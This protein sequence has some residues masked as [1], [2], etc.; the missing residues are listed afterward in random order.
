MTSKISNPVL[1]SVRRALGRTAPLT[2]LPEP[3][4]SLDEPTV[5]LVH[6]AIGLPELFAKRAAELKML[7]DFVSPEQLP[8]R[9]AD[10]LR[11]RSINRIAASVSPLFEK[12]NLYAGL[13]DAGVDVRRWDEISLD[14]MY[15]IDCGLTDANY[16]VAE[17]GSIVIRTT[18]GHGRGISLVPM[19]HIAVLEPKNFL[20]DLLDLFEK[21]GKEGVGQNVTLISG[22][23]KTA[24]IEMN[25]VTGVHGPNVV[26]AFILA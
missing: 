24:D 23:S 22:P 14:E 16:A 20:P 26:Q 2:E 9:I 21:L 11:E 15:D 19:V 3:P 25:V 7:V 4:P 17:T 6:T 8:G 18:A 1:D 5:R 10:F 12:L 13:A